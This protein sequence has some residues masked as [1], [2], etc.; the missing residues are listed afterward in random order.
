M[1]KLFALALVVSCSAASAQTPAANPMPDG[2]R[3]MYAGL[4][5][6]S[7]P[8]YEGADSNKL[9]PLP[10][11]QIQWSNG[12]FI[13]GLS[14][15]MHLSNQPTV[16]FGPLLALQPHRDDGG[17]G[18]GA[19][20]IGAMSGLSMLIQ[21]A[22][23]GNRLAGMEKIYARLQ[24]GGF[25]NYYLTP[26]WRLTTSLLYGAGN[27]RKGARL[28]LGVQRLAAQIGSRHA[29]SVSARV[30]VANR[31]YNQDFFGVSLAEAA[32]SGNPFYAAAGGLQDAG[33]GA[34]WNWKVT[35]SWLVASSVQVTRLLG[36]AKNSP[37][38]E[39]PTNLTVSS[40]VAYRF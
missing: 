5:S 28:T 33:I 2:S 34:R 10:V 6:V 20:D 13:S 17:N 14:A 22:D 3:D 32:A 8:R 23:E 15:G 24:A 9:T 27:E 37:L 31:E 18:R 38:V 11:L 21:R 4:G 12:F 30:T 29:L 39:R 35:P 36:S 19:G 7:A 26:Q 40:A 25:F 16:E 1:E